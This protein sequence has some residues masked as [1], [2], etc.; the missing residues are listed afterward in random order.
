MKKSY[1]FIFNKSLGSL[2]DVANYVDSS[3]LIT[4]WRKELNSAYFIVSTSTAEELYEDI[5]SHFGEGVGTFL[6]SEYSQNSQ[7]LL[8]E[9][10]WHLL[11]EKKLPPKPK[12][13]NS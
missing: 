6:V 3:S 5:S 13:K 7:G 4:S 9:R 11:N 2:E 8:N 12:R 1:L 10:S